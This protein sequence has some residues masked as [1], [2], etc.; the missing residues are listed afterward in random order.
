MNS[1]SPL[2]ETNPAIYGSLRQ[3]LKLFGGPSTTEISDDKKKEFN[4]KLLKMIVVDFQLLFF[5]ESKGFKD[6]AKSLNALYTIPRRK[7]LTETLLKDKFVKVN[8]V[9]V[10]TDIWTSDSNIA[11]VSLACHFSYKDKLISQV[12]STDEI[13]GAHAATEKLKAAQVQMGFL[14]LKIKQDLATRWNSTLF[15]FERLLE[16][17]DALFV[18]VSSLPQAPPSLN[19]TEWSIVWD[20]VPVLKPIEIMTENG[21]AGRDW[22]EEYLRR[23]PQIR[24]RKPE[25]TA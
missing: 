2:L 8:Y 18:T 9:S 19:A 12:L 15:M 25:S 7:Y 3:Q 13:S 23:N 22:S 24:L 17:K 20:C 4:D 10:T 11:H 14:V 21:S 1:L 6:F 16:I 5:V